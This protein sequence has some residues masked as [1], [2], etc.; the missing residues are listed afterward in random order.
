M[1]FG[2]FFLMQRDETW[3]EQHVYDSALEQML[4]AEPMGYHSV[5]IAEHAF[6]EHGIISSPHSLL[7]AIA[8]QTTRVKVG[9]ACSIV[10]WYHPLRLAQ[11]LAT[12]DI[13]SQGRLIVGVGRGYQKR[14][15][16]AYGLDIAESRERFIEGMDIAPEMPERARA[17]A[18]ASGLAVT[19]FEGDA[20]ALALPDECYDLVVERHVIWTV[21]SPETALREWRRVL[22][23]GGTVALVEGAW[24]ARDRVQPD[25]ETIHE[26][27]PLYGGRPPEVL[28]ALAAGAIDLARARVIGDG[29]SHLDEAAARAIADIILPEAGELTTGELAARLRR[30]CLQADPEAGRR[31]YE[32]AVADRH[33]YAR[34]NPEGTGNLYGIDLPADREWS[35]DGRLVDRHGRGRPMCFPPLPGPGL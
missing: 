19:F 26:A 9:V 18:E 31:R 29:T 21:P 7:A 27:L 2:L 34:P 30:L 23:P 28:A 14:E 35:G 25:Y 3:T 33:V 32:A 4:A 11:D 24:G 15:F 16:D 1:D 6:S 10:P 5:W 17:K 8:A 13:I 22:R 12:L 20:E